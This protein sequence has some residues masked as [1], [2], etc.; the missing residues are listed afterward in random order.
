VTS[1]PAENG[2]FAIHLPNPSGDCGS[3]CKCDWGQ[4]VWFACPGDL[5]F[6]VSQC[7]SKL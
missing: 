5:H 4:A 7:W 3:F 1:C 6:N 2:E